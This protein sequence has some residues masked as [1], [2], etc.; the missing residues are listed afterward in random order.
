MKKECNSS[1]NGSTTCGGKTP[2]QVSGNMADY[3]P[4]ID[5][6][7]EMVENDFGYDVTSEHVPTGMAM[8]K[9]AT[10]LE[11]LDWHLYSTQTITME[12]ARQKIKW[13]ADLMDK[14]FDIEYKR[15]PR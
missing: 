11:A 14:K 15:L 10:F 6:S 9:M 7:L 1:P 13:A 8:L 3:D 4:A 5:E 12:E 2:F